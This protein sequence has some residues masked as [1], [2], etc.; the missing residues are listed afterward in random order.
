MLSKKIQNYLFLL[1]FMVMVSSFLPLV[2][3]NLPL[4]LRSHHLWTTLWFVSLVFFKTSI[5]KDKI[6]IYTLIYGITFCFIFISVIYSNLD[7]EEVFPIRNEF[8]HI[9]TA[10]SILRYFILEKDYY[11]LAKLVK[12]TIYFI[13]ITALCSIVTTIFNP[14]YARDL[15]GKS[16]L[17]GA[18][19]EA[20]LEYKKLGGGQYDFF[21]G[22]VCLI[23][24]LAYWYN[25]NNKS[26]WSKRVLIIFISILFVCLVRVQIF[27][28]I[29]ISAISI[30]TLLFMSTNRV[31]NILVI[32][33]I[34]IILTFIPDYY[35]IEMFEFIASKFDQDSELHYKFADF[36]DYL[37]YGDTETTGA[38]GRA[39]RFPLLLESFLSNPL[40]GGEYRNHHMYW[41]NKLATFGLLGTVPFLLLIIYVFKKTAIHFDKDY[42]FYF[43][44]SIFS[45]IILGFLKALGGRNLW[46]VYFIILPGLFYLNLLKEKLDVKQK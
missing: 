2:F 1:A 4:P 40:T 25:N 41:M 13:I 27:A 9:I 29:L 34:G 17:I 28:N 7:D 12:T 18:D 24:V 43:Y 33:F 45:I 21:S 37:K 20:V 44:F 22:I 31:R 32:G 6:F 5:F 8:Y 35:Y 26:I 39:E 46:Y 15:I 30:I 19:L 16:E 14:M 23:P 11:G 10:I 36:A 3:V 42:K 38:S